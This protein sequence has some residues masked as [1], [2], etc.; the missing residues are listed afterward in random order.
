LRSPLWRASVLGSGTRLRS[1]GVSCGGCGRRLWPAWTNDRQAW[2]D[3]SDHEAESRPAMY[4]SI[5]APWRR[6]TSMPSAMSLPPSRLRRRGCRQHVAACSGRSTS[7]SRSLR[8]GHASAE[9][10]ISGGSCTVGSTL[11]EI[12][13]IRTRP[14]S[15][16]ALSQLRPSPASSRY[17]AAVRSESFSSAGSSSRGSLPRGLPPPASEGGVTRQVSVAARSAQPSSRTEP[18][19]SLA[20]RPPRGQRSPVGHRWL[21]VPAASPTSRPCARSCW[22]P[23]P[24][25][26]RSRRPST[27]NP[28]RA[29]C[30]ASRAR[31]SPRQR[32]CSRELMARFAV[33]PRNGGAIYTDRLHLEDGAATR[34]KRP[35]RR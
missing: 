28:R 5:Q 26:R 24:A 15:L 7:A 4:L 34:A 27:S 3:T 19:F 13:S 8:L 11:F 14:P 21:N 18:W 25:T 6:Q 35:T 30:P 32:R 2:D 9:F 1:C 23:P 33:R 12:S 20:Q 29:P 17:P 22:K 16:A 10:Q 31:L